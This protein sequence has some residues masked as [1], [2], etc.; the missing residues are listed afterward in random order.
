MIS[1]EVPDILT[2]YFLNKT[3]FS[4]LKISLNLVIIKYILFLYK[5]II[6]FYSSSFVFSLQIRLHFGIYTHNNVHY[7]IIIVLINYI[8]NYFII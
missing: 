4:N 5:Q 8:N 7:K 6:E 2:E 1:A 3:V